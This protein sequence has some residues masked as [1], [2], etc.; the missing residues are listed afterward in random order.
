MS[1][2]QLAADSQMDPL[3]NEIESPRAKLVYL[4]LTTASGGTVGELQRAL[5]LKKITLYSILRTLR[6]RGLVEK[7]VD[8]YFVGGR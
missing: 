3:P 5:G 6:D 8:G 7:N 4:Y 2:K 1:V